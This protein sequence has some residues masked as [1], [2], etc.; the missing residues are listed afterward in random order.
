MHSIYKNISMTFLAGSHVSD[1]CPLG[2]LFFLFSYRFL[3]LALCVNY[4]EKEYE[5][6]D[7]VK[8]TNLQQNRSRKGKL[9]Q[10]YGLGVTCLYVILVLSHFGFSGRILVLR[11]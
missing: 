11:F 3:L 9:C 6:H 1:R 5:R 10:P 4:V 7:Y 8:Q 2:D